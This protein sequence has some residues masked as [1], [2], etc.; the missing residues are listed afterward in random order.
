[1]ATWQHNCQRIAAQSR[2]LPWVFK[3]QWWLMRPAGCNLRST[4]EECVLSRGMHWLIDWRLITN[5]PVTTAAD[6]IEKLDWYAM[7]WKIEVFHKILKSG[8]RAEDAKLR[9]AG[10]L[11]NLIAIFC[12]ISWCIFWMTMMS[13]IAPDAPPTLVFTVEECTI[14]DDTIRRPTD[15]PSAPALAKYSDSVARLGGYMARSHDPSPGN[16]VMWRG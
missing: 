14:L 11:V 4:D 13:R 16:T 1:M 3:R 10:R 15:K 12:V 7:R 8:C 5:L 6:A 2:G 9:T